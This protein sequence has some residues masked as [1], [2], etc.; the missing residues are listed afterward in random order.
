MNARPHRTH[1]HTGDLMPNE[2]VPLRKLI[3]DTAEQL[4]EVTV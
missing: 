4:D 2:I 1:H 3:A